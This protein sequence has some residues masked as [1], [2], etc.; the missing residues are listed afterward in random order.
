MKHNIS[1]SITINANSETIWSILMDTESYPQWNSFVR[2]VNRKFELG[3]TV[4]VS[5][6]P[7]EGSEMIFK[8]VITT[9]KENQTLKWRGKLWVKGLFDG[10]HCFELESISTNK[11][12]FHHYENFNGILVPLLKKALDTKTKNG[13][14]KMNELLKER[15]EKMTK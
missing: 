5:L 4:T 13:F 2:S 8:P 14:I 3:K 7:P 15:A 10:E 9:L 11:T 6:T 1:T 12:K